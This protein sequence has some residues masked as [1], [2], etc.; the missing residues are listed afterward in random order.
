MYSSLGQEA[1]SVGTAF[2]ERK[3]MRM[4]G[5]AEHDDASYVPK[6]TLDKWRKKDPILR[7]EKY[8][9][10]KKLMTAEEKGGLE[11]RVEKEIRDDVAFAE[12]SPFPAPEQASRCVWV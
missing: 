2:I 10:E 9:C 8:L 1:T 5:H 4:K 3:T 12:A 11:A 7:Y 6:G